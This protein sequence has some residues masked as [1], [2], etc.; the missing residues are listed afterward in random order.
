MPCYLRQM[1]AD[2]VKQINKETAKQGKK[3]PTKTLSKAVLKEALKNGQ[4]TP[5][6][7]QALISMIDACVEE[8]GHVHAD[9]EKV[10]A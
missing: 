4:I 7:Y 5:S 1:E 10:R 3:L 8:K 9:E 2:L 6:K